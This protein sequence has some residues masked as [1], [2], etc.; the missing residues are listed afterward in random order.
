MDDQFFIRR[1][2]ISGINALSQLYQKTYRETYAED[3]SIPY[4]ENDLEAY[5]RSSASPESF[6]KKIIDLKRTIWVKADKRNGDLIAFA[7]T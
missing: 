2:D 1:A 3:F 7:S 4:P 6:A 5:F